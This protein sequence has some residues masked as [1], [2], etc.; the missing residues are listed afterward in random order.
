MS[1]G[2]VA[3]ILEDP[4][5]P[6]LNNIATIFSDQ[7]ERAQQI[8]YLLE[9]MDVAS[10]SRSITGQTFSSLTN[11][12]ADLKKLMD[13]L[14]TIK[15]GVLN[16]Q[17]TIMRNLGD[18]LSKGKRKSIQEAANSIMNDRAANPEALADIMELVA[19]G[20]D[21]SAIKKMT[22]LAARPTYYGYGEEQEQMY[23]A[24]ETPQPQ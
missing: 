11:Y 7:P 17:A 15:Y 22:K 6:V 19:R 5:S 14:I 3:T 8:V 4:A 13:R 16:P 12:D 23:G 18:A 21:E 10:G 20:Q 24:F 2:A 9:M 1:P